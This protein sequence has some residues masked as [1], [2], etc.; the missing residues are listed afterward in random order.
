M[1]N[2]DRIK[3]EGIENELKLKADTLR[4]AIEWSDFFKELFAYTKSHCYKGTKY[5][6]HKRRKL[7][8]VCTSEKIR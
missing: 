8:K 5:L 4:E 7:F 3:I 6:S 1:V 2:P